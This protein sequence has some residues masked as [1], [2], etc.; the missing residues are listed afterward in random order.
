MGPVAATIDAS[1]STVDSR[2]LL[3]PTGDTTPKSN[4]MSN[5]EPIWNSKGGVLQHLENA[6]RNALVATSSQL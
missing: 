4:H 5:S 3:N 2:G 1:Y 6:T